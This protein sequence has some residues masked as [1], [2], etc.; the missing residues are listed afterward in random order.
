MGLFHFARKRRASAQGFA[1]KS[2]MTPLDL[3]AFILEPILTP[4]GLVD[5]PD[6]T[7]HVL[8]WAD[9][10]GTDWHLANND[11]TAL[12]DAS[13]ADPTLAHATSAGAASHAATPGDHALVMSGSGYGSA[14]AAATDHPITGGGY[15]DAGT[16]AP[17]T[18]SGEAHANT[19][20]SPR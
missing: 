12:P 6:H 10:P 5:A 16:P 15:G 3:Q 19:P 13:H 9:H 1:A 18:Q 7:P 14:Q 11:L 2:D 17:T 20:V 4:S 8:D